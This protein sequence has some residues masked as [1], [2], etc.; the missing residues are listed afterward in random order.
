[1]TQ[2]STS[3]DMFPLLARSQMSEREVSF[4]LADLPDGESDIVSLA[5]HPDSLVWRRAFP[6]SAVFASPQPLMTQAFFLLD[7][8][9]LEPGTM[10]RENQSERLAFLQEAVDTAL[11]HLLHLLHRHRLVYH[12]PDLLSAVFLT[13]VCHK[14][15]GPLTSVL[16]YFSTLLLY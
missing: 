2:R 10:T 15:R 12:I 3:T 4:L 14:L 6:L 11:L 5:H 13:T 7:Y 9:G 16:V 1:M 8:S